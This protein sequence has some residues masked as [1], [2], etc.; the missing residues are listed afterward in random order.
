MARSGDEIENP[1]FGMRIVFRQTG[2]ET[3]G[4]L[5]QMDAYLKPSHGY[6]QPHFHPG[7]EEQITCV[8]GLMKGKVRD[9]D[10]TIEPGQTQVMPPGTPHVF[11]AEGETQIRFEFRPAR[12]V[13]TLFETLFGLARD[14][15]LPK[16]G[17]PRLLQTAVIFREY[18]QEIRPAGAPDFIIGALDR[19][20]PIAWKLGRRPW[21]PEY[22]RAVPP[23]EPGGSVTPVEG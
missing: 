14:G 8:S 7:T 2:E 17:R 16:S 10:V 4:E 23:S 13:E 1:M 20:A 12:R 22:T 3:N 15:K 19:I 21:Y 5:L 11:L 6:D 18:K 9:E